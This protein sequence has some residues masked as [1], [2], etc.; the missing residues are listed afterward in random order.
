MAS[1]RTAPGMFSCYGEVA[2]RG[3]IDADLWV[4]A[5]VA[6]CYRVRAFVTI[7]EGHS[8]EVVIDVMPPAGLLGFV[9]APREE[10]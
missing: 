7:A 5:P 9:K 8:V 3:G 1:E 4:F 6:G 2:R 10:K